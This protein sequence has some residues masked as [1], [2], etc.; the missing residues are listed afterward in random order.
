MEMALS[1]LTRL[2]GLALLNDCLRILRAGG[3]LRANE[4]DF[5]DWER[6]WHEVE[7]PFADMTRAER[8]FEWSR[9]YGWNMIY[10]RETLTKFLLEAKNSAKL[11]LDT[12]DSLTR[13]EKEILTIIACGA[14]NEKIADEL[15][16]SPHTV[17]CHIYN[18][19]QKINVSNR[20]QA[21]LWAAKN[22]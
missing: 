13:R 9:R 5:A 17:K 3:I 14:N 15:C 2:D 8:H 20:L 19:Y 11:E 18:I 12:T 22:L 16:I 4:Y 7:E 1:Q 6:R 10:D 21:A